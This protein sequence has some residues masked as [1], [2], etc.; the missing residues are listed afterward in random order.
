MKRYGL[1]IPWILLFGVLAGAFKLPAAEVRDRAEAEGKLMFYAAFN[2]NDS[3]TL[4]D[5]FK[6]LYPKIDAVFYRATD[7]QLMER[8][9][10]ENRAGQNLWDVV[11]S[12]SFYGHNLK[13][14]SLLAPY[15]SPE[16]KYYRDGYKDP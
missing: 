10:T 3:K 13:K 5:G 12:T 14:R 16:R 11:M 8:I 4:T 1:P 15:D 6:Q 2:A 7:A 9:L